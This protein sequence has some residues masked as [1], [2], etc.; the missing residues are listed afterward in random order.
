MEILNPEEQTEQAKKSYQQGDYQTAAQQFQAAAQAYRDQ[1][2]QALAAE[3][4]NNQ[5]VAHLQDDDAQAAL[6]CV[7]G[8]DKVFEQVGDKL[9]L[10]MALGNQAAA[11]EALGRLEEAE[12]NYVRS[13]DLLKELGEDELRAQ[14]MKSIS[15]VQMRSGRQLEALASMQAGVSGLKKP[16]LAQRWLKKLLDLPSKF[17]NR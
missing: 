1:G 4:A 2:K 3:M 6:D 5:S 8:T 11:Q 7:L 16:T 12:T 14:V 17:L 9:K 15:G 13:A 10:A